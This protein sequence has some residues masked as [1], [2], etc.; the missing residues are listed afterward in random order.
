[1]KK[2]LLSLC[3]ALTL[4][5]GATACA[6]TPSDAAPSPTPEESPASTMVAPTIY[7]ETMRLDWN[8]TAYLPAGFD[9]PENADKTYPVIYL[10]HG[11]YGNHRNLVERFSTQEIMDRLIA[12]GKMPEAVVIFVDG[13]NSYYIDGPAFAMEDAIINDL[14]PQVEALYRGMGTKEGRAIG[15]ISMG[16]YGSARFALKYPELFSAAALISPAVWE[17]P[18]AGNDVR[19]SWHVFQDSTSNFSQEIWAQEHPSAFLDSYAEKNSPVDFFLISG[20]ADE[21]V[22][23]GEVKAFADQ[24]STVA[25]QVTTQ[26]DPDGIHGWTYWSGATEK[27]LEHIGSV[28]LENAQ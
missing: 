2:A 18:E 15:G 28:L 19:D 4:V 13:F 17:A 6:G 12:E 22:A 21:T 26:Y 20:E 5:F 16:G 10:L 23:V 3:L 1:M 27:A 11:A 9:D 25:D 8:Y 7:S 24:L 14:I